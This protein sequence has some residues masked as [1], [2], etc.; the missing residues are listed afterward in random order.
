MSMIRYPP[1]PQAP[2]ILE[3]GPSDSDLVVKEGS[4]LYHPRRDGRFPYLYRVKSH[5]QV[6]EMIDKTV[7]NNIFVYIQDT[8]PTALKRLLDFE[9]RLFVPLGPDSSMHD[10][11]MKNLPIYQ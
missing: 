2:F 7:I 9:D 8:E 3:S 4:L 1:D 11:G 6:E 10:L 5:P